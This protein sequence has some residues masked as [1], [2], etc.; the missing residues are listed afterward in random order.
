ESTLRAQLERTPDDA[1]LSSALADL[2]ADAPHPNDTSPARAC[3]DVVSASCRNATTVGH[4]PSVPARAA[5]AKAGGPA[6]PA[7]RERA[8]PS[9]PLPQQ[10]LA[11]VTQAE[12][13]PDLSAGLIAA[14]QTRRFDVAERQADLLLARDSGRAGLFDE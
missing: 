9:A 8:Q 2:R 11:G 1:R 6:T 4:R 10:L 13:A 5:D 3:T 12:H 7:R 14:L